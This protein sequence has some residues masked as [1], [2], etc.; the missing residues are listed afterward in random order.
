MEAIATP[1]LKQANETLNTIFDRRSVRKY[2]SRPVSKKWIEKIIEAGRM[3]PSAMNKQPW[4]FYVVTNKA[5]IHTLSQE[6]CSQALRAGMKNGIRQILEALTSLL[7]FAKRF[8]LSTLSDPVF[9]GAPVVIF[10]TAPT[11]EE[12]AS[13]DIGMCAQNMLLAAKSIGLDG[14]PIGF[15]KFVDHTS[16][17]HLLE[18]PEGEKVC[19]SLIL[20]YGDEEPPAHKRVTDNVQYIQ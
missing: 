12:W 6:I 9:Y 20:G 17:Y 18:I 15:G 19:L 3:A 8:S 11:K 1:D 16:H 10:I 2:K 14:C 7:H 5:I 13:L 4:K